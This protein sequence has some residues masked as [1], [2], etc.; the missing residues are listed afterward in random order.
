MPDVGKAIRSMWIGRCTL[1]NYVEKYD[2]VTRQT[3]HK[4]E[5]VCKDEPCRVSYQREFTKPSYIEQGAGTADQRITLHIR[6]DLCIEA[7]SVIE[8]TQRNIT[9]R[10]KRASAPMVYTHHQEVW[11]ELYED[12]V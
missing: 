11:L 6:P 12:Y 8:V 5:I 9:Q 3:T 1:Y 10:Y 4:E 2:P 7:G